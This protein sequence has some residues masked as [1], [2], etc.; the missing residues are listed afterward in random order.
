MSQEKGWTAFLGSF[1][2]TTLQQLLEL[3]GAKGP[4]LRP[5]HGS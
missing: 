2:G 1:R 3:E 5:L 4:P